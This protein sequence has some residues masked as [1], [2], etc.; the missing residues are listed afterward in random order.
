MNHIKDI[1]RPLVA[2]MNRKEKVETRLNF[3]AETTSERE[4]EIKAGRLVM[5][6]K[7][8][9]EGRAHSSGLE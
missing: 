8:Q 5:D 2:E 3:Y 9:G 1:L 4:N 7:E 6:E